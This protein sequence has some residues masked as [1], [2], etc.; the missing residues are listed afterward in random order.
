MCVP[1]FVDAAE[2]PKSEIGPPAE[3]YES[4]TDQGLTFPFPA[5]DQGT[6][7]SKRGPGMMNHDVSSLKMTF[8][9]GKSLSTTDLISLGWVLSTS[10]AN[11]SVVADAYQDL[12]S[13]LSPETLELL[14][15]PVLVDSDGLYRDSESAILLQALA[16]LY[17]ND[18]HQRLPHPSAPSSVDMLDKSS[19]PFVAHAFVL[20]SDTLE[21]ALELLQHEG[22]GE[23]LTDYLDTQVDPDWKNRVLQRI[24]D[25]NVREY[26][27]Q[28]LQPPPPDYAES[29]STY[30]RT[31]PPPTQSP[32]M[33][34]KMD[35]EQAIQHHIDQIRQVLPELGEGFI[36]M[37]LSYFRGDVE[38]CL[39]TLVDGED[40][41]PST[42]RLLDTTLPRRQYRKN[43]NPEEERQAKE[44]TKKTLQKQE[45]E[46]ERAFAAYERVYAHD[47]Y[48]DD[49]DDQYDAI[50]AVPSN[51]ADYNM[52]DIKLYNRV[53]RDDEADLTF[54]QENRN[55]NNKKSRQKNEFGPDKIKGGRLP[56]P[57]PPPST[58]KAGQ[59]RKARKM[60]NRKEKQKNA[61]AKKAG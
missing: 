25:E 52:E 37:A 30:H 21:T 32:V 13:K 20:R 54:W 58:S 45:R 41:W 40:A 47:E 7:I 16:A 6:K 38:T 10:A 33:P 48:N 56:K 50:D 36:E 27:Q 34:I 39:S 26:Y 29:L 17:R 35:P 46:R 60:E 2:G 8:Q 19:I 49:Y 43:A 57:E 51:N 59:R 55:T 53:M 24:P 22:L 44:L 1:W 12:L 11:E 9:E 23:R 18:V 3:K 5:R 61:S 14:L 4:S 42:L 31:S 28:L 15:Q